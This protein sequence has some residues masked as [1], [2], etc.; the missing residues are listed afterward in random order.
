MFLAAVL[1]GP[2][3]TAAGASRPR[4]PPFSAAAGLAGGVAGVAG[5]LL[6]GRQGEG[7]GLLVG[8]QGGGAFRRLCL[9][10]RLFG[11]LAFL[12]GNAGRRLRGLP[13]RLR[14]AGG[15]ALGGAGLAGDRDRLLG[16]LAF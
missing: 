16:R 3:G 8:G 2:P 7:A 13:R 15:L 1:P 4:E 9:P 14:L 5:R 12:F 10:D 11:G 6:L